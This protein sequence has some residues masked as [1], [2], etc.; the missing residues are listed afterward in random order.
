MIATD[1][2]AKN[3]NASAANWKTGCGCLK[4]TLQKPLRWTR[5]RKE[6]KES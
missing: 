4:E 3:R 2:Q 5:A 6:E 1:G